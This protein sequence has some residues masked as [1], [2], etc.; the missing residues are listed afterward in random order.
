MTN[1]F[2]P[3]HSRNRGVRLQSK[4]NLM[5]LRKN[6]H[7]KVF[8]MLEWTI[9]SPFMW[10]KRYC[11][12]CNLLLDTFPFR[13]SLK[14]PKFHGISITSKRKD[15]YTDFFLIFNFFFTKSF[16]AKSNNYIILNFYMA[17]ETNL[18]GEVYFR[19]FTG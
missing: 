2:E 4:W 5:L 1:Y 8:S 13:M 16:I 15:L 6:T 12:H 19:D 18:N 7:I 10:M 14:K 3:Q 9:K 17:Q 11:T